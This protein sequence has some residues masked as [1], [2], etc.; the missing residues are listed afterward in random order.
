MIQYLF[1]KFSQLHEAHDVL[2]SLQILHSSICSPYLCA[3]YLNPTFLAILINTVS[4]FTPFYQRLFCLI[5]HQLHHHIPH[6]R[7]FLSL[8]VLLPQDYISSRYVIK[9]ALSQFSFNFSFPSNSTLTKIIW[10][11]FFTLS[12]NLKREKWNSPKQFG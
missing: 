11:Y 3:H 7:T 1:L 10:E 12:S 2:S 4:L 5:Y 8:Y 6:Q 9:L